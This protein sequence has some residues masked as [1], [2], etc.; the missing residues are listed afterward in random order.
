M[1]K[2]VLNCYAMSILLYD[3]ECWTISSKMK[4]KLE[5]TEIWF[6]RRIL[7]IPGTE[8]VHNDR[9]LEEMQTK[10]KRKKYITSKEE[11]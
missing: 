4:K 1:K 11:S 8:H 7:R 3:N 2:I 5:T 6:Y 9:G 10:K